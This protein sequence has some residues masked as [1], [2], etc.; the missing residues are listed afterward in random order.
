LPVFN[1]ERFLSSTIESL[2][3]QTY[4]DFELV[5]SDNASTDRTA[6]ICL[7]Y[8]RQDSRVRYHRNNVNIGATQNWYLV[9]RLACGEY[10]ASAAHDDIYDPDYMRTCIALLDADPEVVVCHSRTRIINQSGLPAGTMDVVVDTTSPS[11]HVRLRQLLTHDYKCVQLY[12]VMRSAALAKT[13]VFE[14]YYSADRNTLAELC[15]LGK[16]AEVPEYLFHHRLYPEALGWIMHS[17]KSTEEMAAIDPGT[18]WTR[19][20]TGWI[21]WRNYFRSVWRLVKS[22]AERARCYFVL[23]QVL[24][25]GGMRRFRR[26]LRELTTNSRVKIVLYGHFGSGNIGNDSSL[27]ATLFNLRTR[28]PH[29]RMV[30]V[31]SDPKQVFARFGVAATPIDAASWY[32]APTDRV[33]MRIRR[34]IRWTLKEMK[35]LVAKPL[36]FREASLFVVVGTG[37]VDDMAVKSRLHSPYNLFKWCAAARLGGARV[38]FLSVGVGPIKDPV[39]RSLMLAALRLAHRRTYRERAAL[40]YLQHRGFETSHDAIYPDLAFSLDPSRWPGGPDQA[41]T[42]ARVGLG[43][44]RYLG[45]RHDPAEGEPVFRSYME[46]V[47]SFLRW[48][49]E[50]GHAVRLLVGDATDT[51]CV[52]ELLAFMQTEPM[53]AYRDRL[54]AD[55]MASTDA[56][57]EQISRTDVVVASR[58]HNVLSA[59]LLKR[60]VVSIGYHEK[61]DLLMKAFGME[62]L[63]QHIEALDVERLKVQFEDCVARRAALS[64]DI[65]S[66]LS[67]YRRQLDSQ[68]SE[69]ASIYESRR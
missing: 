67:E 48:L 21:V 7:E 8:A 47:K 17:G 69:L 50:R 68:Y 39:S 32:Q 19:R 5:V 37:A 65:S 51:P 55:E 59:I 23:L 3:A 43:L 16:I 24:A 30:C 40:D 33:W 2:L 1:G 58:F 15:L 13:R 57:L 18:D 35:F 63:C 27:E 66:L 41:R 22:P 45:W 6:T 4:S 31:C 61:N 28:L 46:K 38:V 14:G 64:N 11:A 29:A 9:H 10:F 53:R 54:V 25:A 60:P 49:L 62:G 20:S 56:L 44:I 36:W 34:R 12:G 52:Q 42:P 26:G